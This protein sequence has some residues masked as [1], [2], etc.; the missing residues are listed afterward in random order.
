M[1]IKTV[2]FKENDVHIIPISDLHIGDK[3]FNKESEKK[4]KGYIEW[5]K[6][7]P[8]AR[9]FLLGD[10]LNCATRESK[11]N[12]FDQTMDLKEQIAAAV[13]LF[14]PVKDKIIG[15]VDGNHES[16][17][18]YSQVVTKEGF[19]KVSEVTK[20]D[21]LAQFD[22]NTGEISFAKP[23]E[24]VKHKSDYLINIENNYTKQNVT[25]NH[26]VVV[27][28]EK[29][30]AKD[31]LK[32]K[33]D[34][35]DMRY[36]GYSDIKPIGIDKNILRLLT[37]IVMDGTI[38]DHGK[39]MPNSKKI[40][41]QF[42]LSKQ[43][44]IDALQ[45]LLK[46]CEIPYT[47]KK[48]TKGGINKLQP[49]YIRIYGDY[50]K[51]LFKLLNGKKEFPEQFKFLGKEELLIVLNEIIKTDGYKRYDH[52]LWTSINEKDIDTIFYNC[53][54]NGIPTKKVK[55]ITG[56]GFKNG[57]PQ[58]NLKFY[59]NALKGKNLQKIKTKKIKYGNDAYCFTMPK[60]TLITVL[61][62]KVAFTG[63]CRISNF[64]GYSPTISLCE[65]LGIDYMGDSAVIIFRLGKNSTRGSRASFSGF[66]HHS[67]GGGGSVGSK[68]NVVDK[69][70]KIVCN[71][72]F[73]AIGH[74][75]ML[76]CIHSM[77]YKINETTEKVEEFRQMLVDCGGYIG[78][79]D[80]YAEK[81]M[82]QPLKIG[83]PRI[84]LFIK[85]SGGGKSKGEEKIKKDIHISL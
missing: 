26:D 49:Y 7:T 45:R 73:Y 60:G 19:K 22:I 72:D 10:I 69:L 38:V 29:V 21:E 42:K 31:L 23:L 41:I 82:L 62:G 79:E 36:N 14:E 48:A 20:E 16:V 9:I 59:L 76:G 64:T 67:C 85:R 30:K 61:D 83:S 3:A 55:N 63:N 71:A 35:M 46:E 47:F 43:R 65:R 81:L 15:A 77:I 66:F 11:T 54:L 39:Y 74:N 8:N 58:F 13:K 18:C 32:D 12:P 25:L 27:G 56:S 50:S 53:I 80:S 52:Y 37:W 75:H 4:V 1:K 24:F 33:P 5:V 34:K 68:M 44:K 70:R 2:C 84:H 28:K 51:N 78:Y 57:K 6:K 40:R 17:S